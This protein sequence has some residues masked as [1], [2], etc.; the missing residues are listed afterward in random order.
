MKKASEFL[1]DVRAAS[2]VLVGLWAFMLWSLAGTAPP[3]GEGMAWYSMLFLFPA[4]VNELCKNKVFRSS[5][6]GFFVFLRGT[7]AISR[8]LFQVWSLTVF[9]AITDPALVGSAL[10]LTVVFLLPAAI[11]EGFTNP[12]FSKVSIDPFMAMDGTFPR[13]DE[14]PGAQGAKAAQE[15]PLQR[16]AFAATHEEGKGASG[17]KGLFSNKR[18]IWGIVCV[19]L[20]L[21]A[22]LQ[23]KFAEDIV[24]LEA[25]AMNS[26]LF[27]LGGIFLLVFSLAPA[28]TPE[29]VHAQAQRRKNLRQSQ[30]VL[31]WAV[32]FVG[33]CFSLGLIAP[34][35]MLMYDGVVRPYPLGTLAALSAVGLGGAV[36]LAF[37]VHMLNK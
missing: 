9:S 17:S 3:E 28:K 11:L 19:A 25:M 12:F 5:S 18:R 20:A 23:G 13:P 26:I 6:S 10:V 22:S 4:V 29:E 7:K 31:G 37:G 36:L 27:G 21:L 1:K 14:A 30:K 33:G 24:T 2:W 15:R 32:C 16:D 8:A 34:L 35:M